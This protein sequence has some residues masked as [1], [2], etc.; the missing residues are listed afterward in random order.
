MIRD[1]LGG[2]AGIA[3]RSATLRSTVKLA[4]KWTEDV[5]NAGGPHPSDLEYCE[6][7][8]DTLWPTG[9]FFD[10]ML[11]LTNSWVR[12]GGMELQGARKGIVS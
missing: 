2:V 8:L 7:D 6:N 12:N 10:Y 9:G 11:V 4:D 5:G 3:D 1:G